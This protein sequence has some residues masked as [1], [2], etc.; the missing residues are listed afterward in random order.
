M[1][2]ER[3]GEQGSEGCSEDGEQM[4]VVAL[5]AID[6]QQQKDARQ[7]DEQE[8]EADV[9]LEEEGNDECDAGGRGAQV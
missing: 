5:A 9:L 4:G 1:Q 3:G 7:R 2:Q 6:G 8:G